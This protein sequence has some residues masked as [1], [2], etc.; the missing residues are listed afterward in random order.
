M[1]NQFDRILDECIDRVTRQGEPVETCLARYPERAADLEP[2]LRVVAKAS[3][4]LAFTPS[5]AA[6]DRG[7]L[8]MQ[9]ELEAL[10]R[11]DAQVRER[12]DGIGTRLFTAPPR[13]AVAAGVVVLAVVGGGAGTVAAASGSLPGDALYPVKRATEEVRLAFQFSQEGKA[14]LHVAYADHRAQEIALL[15]QDGQTEQIPLAEGNLVKNLDQASRIANAIED[16]RVLS[17]LEALVG[18]RA[19]QALATLQAAAQQAPEASRPTALAS[20]KS[21]SAAFGDM[22]EAMKVKAPE[23]AVAV[24]LGSVQFRASD[25]PPPDV[26]QVLVQVSRIQ[27]YLAAGMQSRWITIT[28]AP[29]T[30][31]LLRIAEVQRFLAEQRVQPGTYTKIRL[32]IS[33]ATVVA[34]GA[35][36]QAAIPSNSLSLVRPFQ[37]EPDQTTIIL[38]DF[39]GAS[40][41]RVTGAGG[42]VISPVVNVLVQPP[43]PQ[44]PAQA[45][46]PQQATPGRQQA[47]SSQ[48]A[49]VKTELEGIVESVTDS[50]MVVRGKR[51]TLPTNVPPAERPKVGENVHVEGISQADGALVTTQVQA[52]K[53]IAEPAADRALP[54]KPTPAPATPGP[55]KIEGTIDSFSKRELVVDGKQVHVTSETD[56]QGPAKGGATVVI[57]GTLQADGSIVAKQV[58]VESP[59]P[60]PARIVRPTATPRPLAT[61]RPTETPR[62][63]ATPRPTETRRPTPT[64]RPTTE[65]PATP[66]P[67]P[68]REERPTETP[69]PTATPRPTTERP[70]TPTPRATREERPTETPRPTATLRT[71]ALPTLSPSTPPFA[72]EGTR[73][74]ATPVPQRT[75]EAAAEATP[76]PRR[77]EEPPRPTPTPRLTLLP[78]GTVFPTIESRPSPAPTRVPATPTLAIPVSTSDAK[79][80]PRPTSTPRPTPTPEPTRAPR[81]TPTPKPT[82]TP[83][84]TRPP[85]PTRTPVPTRQ[86]AP[87]ST[88]R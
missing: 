73:P 1:T 81:P 15:V 77:T 54:P 37:V 76:T 75:P 6:K 78:L 22:V 69:R 13:W 51:V 53:K 68:T 62:P 21:S 49:A 47:A 29:Q 58:Q 88:R 60:E 82:E 3:A 38:L 42:Y 71:A 56:V 30:F 52:Q 39:D 61:P 34:K 55:V 85:E 41:L 36:Y 45:Q 43:G 33:G 86:A 19:S 84:P 74:P 46:Q 79:P 59:A 12:P 72:P 32:D 65:R 25:P 28:D 50:E 48:T 87:T 16:P 27:A 44:Q 5:A 20:L 2:V 57:E 18:V 17:Q 14:K 24:A 70:A 64:P 31:D 66:T 4:T 11:K 63:T 35:E 26:E 7:R 67:R 10:R 23:P 8:R 80:T 40:S 83:R 9:A